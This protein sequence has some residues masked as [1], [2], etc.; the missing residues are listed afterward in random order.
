MNK[1]EVTVVSRTDKTTLLYSHDTGFTRYAIDLFDD[2]YACR[3]N[4]VPCFRRGTHDRM[5][6]LHG[7]DL[8][9]LQ[10]RSFC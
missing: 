10:C 4:E 2:S 8:N 7:D 1:S 6:V 3:L 5:A 9:L